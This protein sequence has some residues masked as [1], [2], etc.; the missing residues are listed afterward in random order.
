MTTQ[1][2]FV[3]KNVDER[4]E[5][6][7][8]HTTTNVP[9]PDDPECVYPR[10]VLTSTGTDK[11]NQVT[12]STDFY[13]KYGFNLWTVADQFVDKLKKGDIIMSTSA[14]DDQYNTVHTLRS[15]EQISRDTYHNMYK[16][17]KRLH[18]A[19][20]YRQFVMKLR[21][22]RNI[23]VPKNRTH[24]KLGFKGI[25][26][27]H[28]LNGHYKGK[29]DKASVPAKWCKKN[30]VPEKNLLANYDFIRQKMSDI[31]TK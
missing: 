9:L 31:V 7:H 25:Q 23:S 8:G 20:D 12:M 2:T 14:G 10:L 22:R 4:M 24:T 3:K 27:M 21:H 1:Q 6:Y 29:L 15:I 17:I 5:A 13:Q 18:G 30:G 26:C 11:Y 28:V 16:P 19:K